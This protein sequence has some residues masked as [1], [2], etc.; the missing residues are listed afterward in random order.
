MGCYLAFDLGASSG[1]AVLGTLDAGKKLHLRE[2]HR[3]PNNGVEIDGG[4]HWD[5]TRLQEELLN[6]LREA[7]RVTRDITS[8]GIDTWGV[9]Y[10]LFDRET[11]TL[12]ENPYTYRDKRTAGIDDEVFRLVS[13]R[14][15][16]RATG[17]QHLSIN[18]VFQLFAHWKNNPEL[19]KKSVFLHIPDAL[20]FLL[21]GDFTTEYTAA[22]T[23]GLLNCR[24]RSWD[25]EIIRRLGLPEELFPAIVPPGASGGFIRREITDALNLKPLPLV[26]VA[27]HDTAS[28]VLALPHPERGEFAY[29]SCG[30]WA[31]LG[32]ELD[33]PCLIDRADALNYTNEGGVEGTIR[34]LTNIMGCWLFQECRRFWRSR[35]KDYTFAQMSELARQCERGKF[36]FDVSGEEYLAPGDMPERI[37]RGCAAS[38]GAV[39]ESDGEILRAVYDSLAAEIA[40]NLAALEDLRGR[41]Y[42]RLHIAGGG[43]Q[44]AEL[45]RCIAAACRIPVIAGPVEATVTGNLLMQAR[46]SGEVSGVPEMRRICASSFDLTSYQPGE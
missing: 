15:L 8:V 19:L 30:T 16:Y 27:S 29:L 28:A 43:V 21:G 26:K 6:G 41:K 45:M 10:A 46:A 14:E 2:V 38:G 34:F 12:A 44:D 39:P 42:N 35:G 3:F 1:R 7:A 20:G 13:R 17:I 22:S 36:R 31:L 24:D 37:A 40:G 11:R 25:W 23:S 18:T 32:A 33:S 9:D 4:L 5:L